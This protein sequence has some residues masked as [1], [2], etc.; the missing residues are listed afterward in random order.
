MKC[1]LCPREAAT[2]IRYSSAH[3][4]AEHFKSY[5]EKRAKRE[6]RRQIDV[7]PGSLVAVAVSGGKDSMVT[8]RILHSVFGMRRDVGL[9]AICIDEGIDGYRPPSLDVARGYCEEIGVP[10]RV[11]SF[12]ELGVDMD[13]I[14]PVSGDSSPCS[15]CGVLR[16]RLMNDEARRIGASFLATGHNL[17]DMA[18]SILMNFARG[19]AERLARLGPHSRAQPGLVPRFHPLRMIPEKE[20]LLYAILSETPFWDGECPYYRDAL[21]NQYRRA[22]DEL[23]DG[24]PGTRFGILSSFDAIRPLLPSGGRELRMCACG[25][26]TLG[27]RCKSCEMLDSLRERIRG[28]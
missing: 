28:P 5:F 9:C 13:R 6:I 7:S 19:D 22:V 2:L 16:R 14:A 24:S 1:D 25:E 18:Q 21:R 20:S 4:C 17:D 11:R 3:L 12:S 10:M 8:L 23:E 15:Y 27:S 26:P